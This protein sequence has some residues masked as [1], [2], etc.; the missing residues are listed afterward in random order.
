MEIVSCSDRRW[1]EFSVPVGGAY[2]GGRAKHMASFTFGKMFRE[3]N[4]N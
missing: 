2:W 1:A 3:I 4:V